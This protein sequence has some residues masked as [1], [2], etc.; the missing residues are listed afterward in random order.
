MDFFKF[1]SR[2]FLILGL[3]PVAAFGQVLATINNQKITV[4][5]FNKKYADVK[6]QFINT[7]SPEVFLEDLVRFE[8][9]VQEAEK[10]NLR[11]DPLV[12]ERIRQELYKA[13]LEKEVGARVNNT[14][15]SEAEMRRHYAS[16][17][18]I[19]VSHIL[20]EHKPNATPAEVE[21]TRKRASEILAEIK[22]S[23]RPFEEL[24]KLYS[25]DTLSKNSG[26]DIG[27]H[28]RIT[29]PPL[30]YDAALKLKGAELSN[31]IRSQFGF[32]IIKVT[33]RRP[34]QDANKSQIRTAVFDEKRKQIFDSYFNALKAKYKIQ[35]NKGLVDKL[36]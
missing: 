1:S 19:Q 10:K 31:L 25:D 28:S 32:H 9:G 13:L 35:V 18:Q 14:K 24:A 23:K 21:Q 12:Q 8:V 33:A 29:L 26:G 22:K 17:P 30:V 36:N 15:V 34:Y 20:F 6:K 7:P 3:L 4:E 27:Y 5:E 11:N 16:N 2:I